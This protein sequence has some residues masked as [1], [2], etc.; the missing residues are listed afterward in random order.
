MKLT[1][2][3]KIEVFY[4]TYRHH[5]K[6]KLCNQFIKKVSLYGCEKLINNKFNEK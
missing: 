5:L 1:S 6:K 3:S 4:C 2:H